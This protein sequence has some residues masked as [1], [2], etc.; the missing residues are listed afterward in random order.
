M[1][2][3]VGRILEQLWVGK[4]CFPKKKLKYVVWKVSSIK[5]TVKTR[6]SDGGFEALREP[7]KF[8]KSEHWND[9]VAPTHSR[10]L[11]TFSFIFL[12]A[13]FM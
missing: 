3:D 2:M 5:T 6:V 9:I 10:K 1:D 12:T 11:L 8:L 7:I 4:G 13:L